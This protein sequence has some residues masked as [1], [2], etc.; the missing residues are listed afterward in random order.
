[1][2]IRTAENLR[3]IGG[4]CMYYSALVERTRVEP[5]DRTLIETVEFA[6]SWRGLASSPPLGRFAP[7]AMARG[8]YQHWPLL[9]REQ[10]ST[11]GPQSVAA[12]PGWTVC[13][14]SSC[15]AN[16]SGDVTGSLQL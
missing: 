11:A 13:R 12:L 10:R 8:R 6:M 3:S 16:A 4:A 1:M 9:N 5:L 7:T 15:S 14:A 2:P